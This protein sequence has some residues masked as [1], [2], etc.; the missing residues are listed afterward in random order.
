[1]FQ[2]RFDTEVSLDDGVA[3]IPRSVGDHPQAVILEGL[4]CLQVRE[5]CVV[6]DRGCVGKF[7]EDYYLEEQ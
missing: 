4:H 2:K 7:G 3:D 6:P 1:M 5:S